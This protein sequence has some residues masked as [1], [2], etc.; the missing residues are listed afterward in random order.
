MTRGTDRTTGHGIANGLT[1]RD[2]V[3]DDAETVH[4]FIRDLSAFVKAPEAVRNTPANLGTQLQ[5]PRPPFECVLAETG[6]PPVGFALY[7]TTY[8]TWSGRPGLWLED[9]F[10]REDARGRGVGT[11]LL[12]EVGR[13]AMSRGCVRLD[14]S[15]LD[16]DEA[17]IAFYQR[18][19]GRRLDD[20][21][22][23]RFDDEALARLGIR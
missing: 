17:A 7:F 18:L 5:S 20:A 9:L 22:I 16:W 12:R 6:G 8:G 2:A 19:G 21:R 3:P 10:V 4:G 15:V 23:F 1:L 14:F 11:A 13:R